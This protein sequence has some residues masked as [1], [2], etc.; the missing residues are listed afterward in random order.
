M[1]Q[2]VIS[3]INAMLRGLKYVT[4][5]GNKCKVSKRLR[6]CTTV[7]FTKVIIYYILSEDTRQI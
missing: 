7:T 1:M 2:L 5:S 3:Y 6:V 4:F